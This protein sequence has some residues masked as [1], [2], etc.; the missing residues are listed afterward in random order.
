MTCNEIIQSNETIDIIIPTEFLERPGMEPDCEQPIAGGYTIFYYNRSRVPALAIG[1]YTYSSI[2]KCFGLLDTAAL[3]ESGIL[4]LQTQPSLTLK[5]Q[6]VLMG[7]IDTGI[8]YENA[9]FQNRDG[10][11][12]IKSIW[13][14]TAE[15]DSENAPPD[16]FLYGVEYRK[17]QL[18]AALAS[19]DPRALVPEGDENGHG[20]AVASIA[21]GSADTAADFT[22]AAP[23]ADLVVVKL[24]PAKRYLKDYFFIPENTLCFQENDILTGIAYLEKKSE[25]YGQPIIICL[26]L[27]TNN[28]SHSGGSVLSEYLNYIGGIWR[29]CI[30]CAA[31][32]EALARHHFRGMSQPMD[33]SPMNVEINVDESMRGFYLELWVTAPKL[34]AVSLRSPGGTL[35]PQIPTRANS[36]QE[37]EYRL[38]NAFV[39]IDYRTVGRT[40]GDQ[41][42]FV[43][44]TGAS[45]GIWTLLVYPDTSLTGTFDIWLPMS[46]MLERDVYFL[47]PDPEVTLTVPGTAAIPITVGGYNTT[48]GGIYLSSG[49]GFTVTNVVKPDFAAPAVNIRAADT[50]GRYTAVTGTSAA[51]AITAGAC[52]QIMEW[53]AVR[54]TDLS[55]NSVEIGNILIRGCRRDADRSYPNPQWGYG[56]LDA[57]EAFR[58]L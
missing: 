16:G 9:C 1:E 19:D 55:L 34:F 47:K 53:G 56:K 48:G 21:A 5:G 22:G 41:L 23:L 11:S 27:G 39:T 13:D 26:A 28:G 25:E 31:G 45:R 46:G 38:E 58:Q 32:N 8:A 12:R 51:A 3:E 57:Y 54:R 18:D 49:R 43:R 50:R 44:I 35:L 7:F 52:A 17:A 33:A 36:H 2:P 14:Q 29:R 24:K 37:Y 20:T 42:I 30:V 40:R 6:G 10:S 4:Q 15:P